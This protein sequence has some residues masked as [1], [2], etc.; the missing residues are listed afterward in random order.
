MSKKVLF[1]TIQYSKSTQFSSIWPIDR[2]LSEEV[3]FLARRGN[4]HPPKLQHYWLFTLR[5]FVIS[6]TL[7]EKG[8]YPSAEVQSVYSTASADWAKGSGCSYT[9]PKG[10]NPKVFEIARLEFELTYHDLSVSHS[11]N[12]THPANDSI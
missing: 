8:S 9:F 10:I 6:W 4:T 1:Q 11:N 2:T 5:L 12:W 7:A 3:I